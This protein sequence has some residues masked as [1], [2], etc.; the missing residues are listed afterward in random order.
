MIEIVFFLQ[1][2]DM[3]TQGIDQ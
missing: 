1:I 2:I 3:V